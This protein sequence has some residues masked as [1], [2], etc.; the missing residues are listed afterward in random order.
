MQKLLI[1]S[2]FIFLIFFTRLY[3]LDGTARFTRDESSDLARMHEYYQNKQISLVGPI[4]SEGDKVFS[5]LSYYMILPFA[6][7][8]NFT[9]V[10][11]VYGMAFLGILT[12][13]L[14]FLI[15]RLIL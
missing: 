13:G 12:A 3:N 6:V 9:P 10:S 14:L 8:F 15:A 2:A 7:L 4:S 11:P 5:S 1:F